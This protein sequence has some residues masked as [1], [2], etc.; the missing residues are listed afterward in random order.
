MALSE[1]ML[2]VSQAVMGFQGLLGTDVEDRRL[3]YYR[4]AGV[5]CPG[6]PLVSWRSGTGYPTAAGVRCGS[7]PCCCKTTLDV[8]LSVHQATVYVAANDF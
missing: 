8:F 2:G 3:V 5:I 7:L 6:D 1:R 4:P